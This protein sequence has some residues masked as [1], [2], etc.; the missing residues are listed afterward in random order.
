MSQILT[1]QLPVQMT[2]CLY[3]LPLFFL[4][5]FSGL[6]AQT[7]SIQGVVIQQD[8]D[9][10]IYGAE[11]FIPGTIFATYT[12]EDG[13]FLIEDV[14][15]GTYDIHVQEYVNNDTALYKN[16]KVLSGQTTEI[17]I[18]VKSGGNFV[19]DEGVVIEVHRK[20][21]NLAGALTATLEDDNTKVVVDQK[22]ARDKGDGTA[23]E[24]ARR[25]SG[26]TL[27]GGKYVYV[28]GLSDRYSKTLLNG[29]EIPGLDA[30][31]NS[32]QLDLFPTNFLQSVS[33]IKTYTP[34]LP[35]DFTGGLIDIKMQ[36]YPDSLFIKLNG[37]F[38]YNPQVHLRSDY[39][40]YSRTKTDWL[41]F[42]D[43]TRDIPDVAQQAFDNEEFPGLAD[44]LFNSE[45]AQQLEEINESFNKEVRPS[46][47]NSFVDHQGTFT[48][49]N[50]IDIGRR[51]TTKKPRQFGFFGGLNYKRSFSYFEDYR[52]GLYSLTGPVDEKEQLDS[53][54]DLSGSQSSE[55]ASLGGF[56]STTLIF[57]NHH[58]IGLNLLRNQTG[59]S[60][61]SFIEGFSDDEPDAVLRNSR[62]GYLE[63]A[64]N[65]AQLH[66]THVFDTL[67]FI[68]KQ[69]AE[70]NYISALT[71]SKQD[72]PDIRWYNDDYQV[73]SGSTVY[74]VNAAAYRVP[75]RFWRYMNETNI[76]NKLHFTVSSF[77]DQAEDTLKYQIKVGGSYLYK[78]RN[79]S[80]VRLEYLYGGAEFGAGPYNGDPSYFLDD[81]NLGLIAAGSPN[82]IGIYLSDGLTTPTNNYEALQTVASGYAMIEKPITPKLDFVGGARFEKTDL[83]LVSENP[84]LDPGILDNADILP[85]INFI[86]KI[87]DGMVIYGKDSIGR[88]D[89]SKV[90]RVQH[91]KLRFSVSRT[92]AR[93]SFRE[94]APFTVERYDLNILEKG[95][96]DLE[97]SLID[98]IDLRW[99]VYPS[100]LE[101]ISVG[102]F[103]KSFINPIQKIIIPNASSTEMTWQNIEGKDGSSRAASLY[104]VELEFMKGLGFINPKLDKFSFS[105]NLTLARSQVAIPEDE[106]EAMRT[107]DTYHPDTRPLFGS[108]PYIYNA[109]LQYKTENDSLGKGLSANLTFNVFGKR[110]AIVNRAGTPPI[111]E[112]PR[113]SLD[114]N[115][116]KK[117]SERFSMRFRVRN[118]INPTWRWKYEFVG[119]NSVYDKFD[120]DQEFLLNSYKRGRRFSLSFS[121]NFK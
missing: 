95:N 119:D 70:L 94:I 88:P 101:F 111:Y 4:F 22:T 18:I 19:R 51:D 99:E 63:R 91:M 9:Q 38:G 116:Q 120:K 56:L 49:G 73:I 3:V 41:G 58:K 89:S 100:A 80:E 110:I 75:A 13:S 92:L 2:K 48:I 5:I 78:L 64:I 59:T 62:L 21:D 37:S 69:K 33:V 45:K 79:F 106:L 14:D 118:I 98:N 71:F 81:D 77:A 44:A 61:S 90:D 24:T 103:Y 50:L 105:T 42:D 16:V 109:S 74:D 40:G 114:F 107:Q 11:V 32:V 28:R 76:D 85:S 36:E 23:G 1:R 57:N 104:G 31:R 121:Y 35:G 108:S 113:P 17:E 10:P 29:S 20:E 15:P 6:L 8:G 60:S 115:I 66:G 112:M 93:P 83:E 97:R 87:Q 43:G 65:T 53:L 117:F 12:E 46:D 30:N 25:A 67:L 39:L 55:T 68:K 52:V 34:D 96:P 82:Q 47:Q 102:A 86:Y 84:A 54:R 27:E 26:V 72:E 7:G